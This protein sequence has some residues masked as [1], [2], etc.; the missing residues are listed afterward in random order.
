MNEKVWMVLRPNYVNGTLKDIGLCGAGFLIN[1]NTF[2]TAYHC[3]NES[4][5]VPKEN[6]NNNLLILL[7]PGKQGLKIN[8]NEC[9]FCKNKDITFIKLDSNFDYI[10]KSK[11][12]EG[13]KVYNI[14]YI[15]AK[16]E[17]Y[18][19]NK[20]EINSQ[21]KRN[22]SVIEKCDNYSISAPDV[23]INNVKIIK[24]DYSCEVGF[25]GG[26]LLNN[27]NEV[28]GLMSHKDKST[29]NVIAISSEEF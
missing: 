6:Y 19:N 24:L 3:C 15:S 16:I 10:K 22:G 23:S 27:R 17:R 9:I 25:S 7:P 11:P 2:I 28:I 13:E 1:S 14:G 4:C 5:F 26:P 21:D 20:L 18:V 8:I 29:G 12:V